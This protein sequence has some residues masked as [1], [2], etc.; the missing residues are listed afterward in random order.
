M[1]LLEIGGRGYAFELGSQSADFTPLFDRA[2][3]VTNIQINGPDSN[4]DWLIKVAGKE[5]MSARV[6]SVGNQQPFGE[7]HPISLTAPLVSRIPQ[8]LFT[9]SRDRFG[10]DMSIPVPNGQT[11]T[12]ESENT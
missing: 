11:L 1:Q 5:I 12:I 7:F 9:L 4:D 10:R 8:N 2:A 3:R 6:P